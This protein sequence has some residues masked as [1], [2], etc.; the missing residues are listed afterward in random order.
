MKSKQ[1]KKQHE[2]DSKQK[3]A[4]IS[5]LFDPEDGGDMVVGNVRLSP[6]YKALKARR[7]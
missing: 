4:F 5:L 3:T 1:S 7:P 6:S 2:A